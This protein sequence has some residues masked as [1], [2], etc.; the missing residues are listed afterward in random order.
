MRN[1]ASD[2]LSTQG[3]LSD[4][5]IGSKTTEKL[6]RK[7]GANFQIEPPS[8]ILARTIRSGIFRD[9]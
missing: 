9:F 7:M 8:F 1:A 4:I 3:R 6:A 2:R 5:G